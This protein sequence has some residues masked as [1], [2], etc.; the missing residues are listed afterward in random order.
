[1]LTLAKWDLIDIQNEKT[2][3]LENSDKIINKIKYYIDN[4]ILPDQ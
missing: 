4:L 1:M 3:E 2:H